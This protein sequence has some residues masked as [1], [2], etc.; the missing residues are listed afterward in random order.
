[1]NLVA[2]RVRDWQRYLYIKKKKKKKK[3]SDI[4]QYIQT[5][6]TIKKKKTYSNRSIA[7]DIQKRSEASPSQLFGRQVAF[8]ERPV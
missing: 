3:G 4:Q 2:S 7:R 8:C 5:P 1:V 6:I